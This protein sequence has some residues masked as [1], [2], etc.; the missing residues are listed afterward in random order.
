MEFALGTVC[1]VNLF[2]GG[3]N[4]IYSRV[5]SRIR[6]I[7]RT[8]SA[9]GGDFQDL[10]GGGAA[11]PGAET[12]VSGI[13]AVNGKAGI[14]AVK[15]RADLIG[16]LETALRYAELSNGAFDPTVGPLVSL[17][18]IGTAAQRI[19]EDGE[20]SAALALVSWRDLEVDREAGT[21]FLRREGMALDIG[22][23]AKGYAA[24]EA[25]RIAGEEGVKRAII[26]L[27]G[28]ISALGWREKKKSLP[29]RIGVQNPLG[30]R[31][32]YI[33]VLAVHDMSVVTSGVY[34]RY[35]EAEGKRYHHIL[36][37]TDGCPVDNGLLSVTIVT[38]SSIDA[39]AL[40]TSVFALG[41]ERGKA[42]VDSIPGAEA[43][44][45]FND[46]G[47]RITGGLKEI[48][49]ITDDGYTLY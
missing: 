30:E 15:I 37:T 20:I 14:E 12:L 27:G 47:V 10:L 35:F 21:A 32:S 18:G 43:V 23:I 9:F 38:E 34:E 4:S 22:A 19:P 31:G 3:K 42:L 36:S 45:V 28:N 24:D 7:D 17:W 39:D 44:F 5:F 40:S 29:W 49:T 6:E 46:R 11:R 2:E 33:G 8:M 1:S 16:V 41:F 25:V 26:D 13:V 48:F